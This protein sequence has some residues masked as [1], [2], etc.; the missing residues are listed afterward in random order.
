MFEALV[1]LE[2]R[3]KRLQF[4]FQISVNV[5]NVDAASV[6]NITVPRLFSILSAI[7]V[8]IT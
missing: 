5:L 4:C 1:G 3:K 8:T 6:I 7:Y 2:N